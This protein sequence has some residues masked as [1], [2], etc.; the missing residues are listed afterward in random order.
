[1]SANDSIVRSKWI[2]A[3]LKYNKPKK[4]VMVF[5]GGYHGGAFIF[6]DGKSSPINAPFEFII[7]EYNDISSV[8]EVLAAPQNVDNVAAIIIEPMIG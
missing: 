2:A 8:H 5:D 1:M 4:K 7:A 6:K 3:A